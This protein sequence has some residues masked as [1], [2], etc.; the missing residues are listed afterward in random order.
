MHE[1]PFGLGAM[2]RIAALPGIRPPRAWTPRTPDL[3]LKSWWG[4]H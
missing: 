3:D 1:T 4:L 2:D